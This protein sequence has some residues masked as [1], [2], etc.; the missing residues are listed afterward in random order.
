MGR[1]AQGY[2]LLKRGKVWTVRFRIDGQRRELSTGQSTRGEANRVG[3]ALYA[4]ALHGKL[5]K[6]QCGSAQVG[7]QHELAE[8]LSQWIEEHPL[9]PTTRVTYDKYSKYWLTA[10]ASLRGMTDSTI[11]AY[12]RRRLREV[13]G[14]TVQSELC[15]LRAFLRW[16]SETGYLVEAPTVPNVTKQ[17]AGTPY[18]HRRRA[19]APDLDAEEVEAIL[20]AL[21]ERS[22][23]GFPIRSRF[24]VAYDTT[25]RP[26]TLSRLRYPENWSVGAT[27]IT[28]TDEDDKELYGRIVPLTKRAQKAL[29][30]SCSSQPGLIFGEHRCG[31]YLR[32]AAAK[33]LPQSKADVFTGQHFRS[34]SIT[35]YLEWTGNL[36]GTMMMAG[37]RHAS[38]TSRYVRPTLRAA[39]EMLA[40]SERVK[41]RVKKKKTG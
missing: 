16:A 31:P 1:T 15:A 12:T 40:E 33:V 8:V 20:A 19:R 26:E 39:R 4:D 9:R 10:F 3:R 7:G 35:H 29:A 37:H 25:L 11:G 23:R 32:A 5:P 17:I 41:I 27:E 14:K 13:R 18:K 28:L 6:Q 21:P 2:S 38:T 30:R 34:A 22:T 36:P 24:E